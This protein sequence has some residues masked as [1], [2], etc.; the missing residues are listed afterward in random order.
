[1]HLP[2]FLLPRR[3]LFPF[4]NLSPLC[5]PRPSSP[6]LAPSYRLSFSATLILSLCCCSSKLRTL[7]SCIHYSLM[8]RAGG[9]A[10]PLE[11]WTRRADEG[12]CEG[13]RISSLSRCLLCS[14]D[15][16]LAVNQWRCQERATT[17]E[18]PRFTVAQCCSAARAVQVLRRRAAGTSPRWNRS[19]IIDGCTREKKC[20][21]P[22][23][24]SS[25][26]R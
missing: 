19:A 17:Y 8:C 21:T 22:K 9:G 26:L 4:L 20:F 12:R 25:M 13:A 16:R 18:H 5:R 23:M 7:T 15:G 1:M 6:S 24:I 14:T 11:G 2:T 3:C 10:S